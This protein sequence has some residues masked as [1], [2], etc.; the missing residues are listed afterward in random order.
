MKKNKR[1]IL[2]VGYGQDGKILHE[3]SLKKGME[4]FIIGNKNSLKL[5]NAKISTIDIANK[6]C[7]YCY[8]IT[9][10]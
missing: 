3:K 4:V 1:S 6:L 8:S 5:H 9:T 2:I 10:N 7:C